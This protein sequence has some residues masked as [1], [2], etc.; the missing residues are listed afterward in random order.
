MASLPQ[1]RTR[2]RYRPYPRHSAVCRRRQLC[3]AVFP[4]RPKDTA[5]VIY[6]SP[7]TA[8]PHT[9]CRGQYSLK[10]DYVD[11]ARLMERNWLSG[12]RSLPMAVRFW[13]LR[14]HL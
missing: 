8:V 3:A 1:N 9:L 6:V 13:L 4:G 5:L 7:R 12:A 11:D 2:G 10:R 14:L